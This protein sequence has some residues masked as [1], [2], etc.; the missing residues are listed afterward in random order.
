MM[1]GA[2]FSVDIYMYPHSYTV[3]LGETGFVSWSRDAVPALFYSSCANL[4]QL[5]IV[6]EFLFFSSV[7]RLGNIIFALLATVKI[8]SKGTN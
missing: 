1:V 3:A 6:S 7:K 8:N 2:L 5:L 4:G